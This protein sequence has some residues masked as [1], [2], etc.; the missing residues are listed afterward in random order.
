M[1]GSIEGVKDNIPRFAKTIKHDN[2]ATGDL[3]IKESTVQGYLDEFSS[4]VDAALANLYNVPFNDVPPVIDMIVNSLAAY[5]LARRFWVN[6][7]NEENHSI[8]A[9]RKD[10][11]E[12]LDSIAS[13]SY[14][15]PGMKVITETGDELDEIIQAQSGEEEIFSMGAPSEWQAKL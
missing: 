2:V 11:K 3:D 6:I 4:Q 7:T 13:G 5:K 14:I 8:S 12:L 10:G 15:L 9:L 1:Y